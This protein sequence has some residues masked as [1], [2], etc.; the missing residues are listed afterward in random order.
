MTTDIRKGALIYLLAAI[1]FA[2]AIV[3]LAQTGSDLR[4][5]GVAAATLLG[6]LLARGVATRF[7]TSS[8][9]AFG[10]AMI[11]AGLAA[12][13]T[14]TLLGARAPAGV[15]IVAMAFAALMAPIAALP[16]ATPPRL[17]AARV[18]PLLPLA[19]LL[20]LF[21][22][23]LFLAAVVLRQ[24]AP[25]TAPAEGIVT[26]YAGRLWTLW[27]LLLALPLLALGLGCVGLWR[28]SQAS[29]LGA[30]APLGP[31]RAAVLRLETATAGLILVVVVLH[32]LAT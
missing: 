3:R 17:E 14:A 26:W 22:A 11:L 23:I 15:L 7:R 32:M 9:G 25:L 13:T 30:R 19:E 31:R 18:L 28:A 1:P 5:L 10:L 12:A 29:L 16:S 27:I 6:A 24:I 8:L 2:F 4:Y 21:P 20:F